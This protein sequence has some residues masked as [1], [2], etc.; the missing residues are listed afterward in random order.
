MSPAP[1]RIAA[2]PKLCFACLSSQPAPTGGVRARRVALH[3]AHSAD[4]F[5]VRSARAHHGA[6]TLIFV[7]VLAR[8]RRGPATRRT[9]SWFFTCERCSLADA[10]RSTRSGSTRRRAASGS[11]ASH[12][13]CRFRAIEARIRGATT[14]RSDAARA[15]SRHKQARAWH[16]HCCV[17]GMLKQDDQGRFRLRLDSTP[18]R[19]LCPDSIAVC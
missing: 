5:D 7:G 11:F 13:R 16:D 17:R 8:P 12:A 19:M 3:P 15:R 1:S 2:K 14:S 18:L 10:T 4:R 9:M 6:G